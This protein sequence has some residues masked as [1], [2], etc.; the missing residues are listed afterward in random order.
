MNEKLIN[1]LLSKWKFLVND[2]AIQFVHEKQCELSEKMKSP[3]PE[4]PL[5]ILSNPMKSIDV[6]KDRI[7]EIYPFLKFKLMQY[8][9]DMNLDF[10]SLY[11]LYCEHNFIQIS[12]IKK[13]INL[14]DK[15]TL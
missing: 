3:K 4:T 15:N 1:F 12:K 2:A 6:I 8:E 13:C 14:C 9:D 5:S 11:E 7:G 10:A